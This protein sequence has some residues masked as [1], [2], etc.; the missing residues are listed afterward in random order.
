MCVTNLKTIG[1]SR[2]DVIVHTHVFNMHYTDLKTKLL[3][4]FWVSGSVD[5]NSVWA[6]SI[7][8]FTRKLLS[9]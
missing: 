6:T 2:V 1:K 3:K 4:V 9:V 5:R 8:F 7:D